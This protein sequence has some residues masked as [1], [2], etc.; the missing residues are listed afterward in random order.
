[1]KNKRMNIP[2]FCFFSSIQPKILGC[3]PYIFYAF[4]DS[5]GNLLV[6]YSILNVAHI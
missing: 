3:R 2:H 4:A 1:M 5:E 6:V